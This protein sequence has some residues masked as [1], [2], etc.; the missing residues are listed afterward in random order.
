[1]GTGTEGALGR[2]WLER[3]GAA[4]AV[5]VS[6]AMSASAQDF[7]ASVPRVPE[8]QAPTVGDAPPMA[9]V[10][11]DATPILPRLRGVRFVQDPAAPGGGTD[12]VDV[13]AVPIL[14]TPAFRARAAQD[15]GQPASLASLN[16]LARAAVEAH[17][18][19]GQP[20]VDVAIPEQ[21]ITAGTVTFVVRPFRT[22]AVVVEGNRFFPTERLRGFIRLQP[23]DPI[24]QG[25]L[26]EDLNWIASNPF[27]RVDLVYRRGDAP[28][29]TDVVVRVTDRRP[30]RLYA[31]FENNGAVP[32]GRDR[33]FAGIN[34][35]NAFGA[36]GQL[37]YHYT[38]STD[39]LD[40]R[41][42]APPQFQAHSFTWLQPLAGRQ[43]LVL[44]GTYQRAVP[45]LGPDIGVRGTSWQMSPRLI[46]P[47]HARG[48]ERVQLSFGYDFKQ[49]D[50]N[51]LFGGT[52][53]ST[54]VTEIH[55]FL[56]DATV[57]RRWQGGLTSIENRLTF[58]PGGIGSRN[59]DEAFQPA[60]GREGTP[61]ARAQY[62]YW[63]GVLTHTLPLG[64]DGA[65]SVSRLTAQVSTA[66]LLPSEQFSVAGPGFV[67]AYDPNAVLGTNGV[68]FNQEIW[69]PYFP[70]IAPKSA[71]R[72]GAF[73]DAGMA[74]NPDRLPGEPTSLRTAS[75]GM[76]ARWQI[77]RW[78]DLRA[79]LGAQLR[80]QP[81]RTQ[82]GSLG[83]V[84][85]LVG[86]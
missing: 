85:L 44:F 39:L 80:T 37:A 84:T 18:A 5:A 57:S 33:L 10:P 13:A 69:G 26:I 19:A 41:A 20:L 63:R 11:A 78:I 14:D 17:R 61:F 54:Q 12:G 4:A 70:G 64:D 8:A 73:L 3:G 77:G 1:M 56:V 71:L 86:Y 67:R 66:N 62:L 21:D 7:R 49:T 15:I 30:L 59:T 75:L 22:G 32:T 65:E 82:R 2:A 6:V 50:N 55:Q 9:A 58:A 34:W 48:L 79:D 25:R 31:G 24:D 36:D 53:I 51:L 60:P 83:F 35:G 76:M 29:T 27:R 72:A 43:S 52:T 74:G 47:V 45:D 38:T 81:G 16:A 28:L 68:M 40:N 42:G 46:V 23:G